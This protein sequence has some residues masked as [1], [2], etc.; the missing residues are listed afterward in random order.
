MKKKLGFEFLRFVIIGGINTFSTA[1]IS[2]LLN[3]VLTYNISFIVGYASGLVISFFLNTCFT[4]KKRPTLKRLI[5]FPIS[6]APNFVAQYLSVV[7]LV[8][9]LHISSTLAYFAAAIIGVPVTFIVMRFVI[10]KVR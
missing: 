7:L 4:F 9:K 10:T 8:E 6:Y 2:T 3:K 5:F 1:L